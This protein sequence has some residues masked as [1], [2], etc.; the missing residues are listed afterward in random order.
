MLLEAICCIPPARLKV[1]PIFKSEKTFFWHFGF[2]SVL[3]FYTPPP[4]HYSSYFSGLVRGS[5]K[6]VAIFFYKI[7]FIFFYWLSKK[8]QLAYLNFSTK[9]LITF[10]KIFIL[11]F[12]LYHYFKLHICVCVWI[13]SILV[14]LQPFIMLIDP[15]S[16]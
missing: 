16:P 10:L 3:Q 5:K 8:I 4:L 11:V 14:T 7:G 13:C 15:E 2:S 12:H 9:I 6:G 1:P